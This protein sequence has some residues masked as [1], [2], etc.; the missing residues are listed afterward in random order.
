MRHRTGQRGGVATGNEDLGAGPHGFGAEFRQQGQYVGLI[1]VL[2]ADGAV[3]CWGHN[4]Y[5]ELGDGS[6]TG[7]MAF[8]HDPHE[9]FA[10]MVN[11]A[12]VVWRRLAS[13]H[14]ETALLDLIA[15][16]ARET[17]SPFAEDLLRDW[18]RARG[19]FWQVCPKEMLGRLEQPLDDGAA[20]ERA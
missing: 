20:L 18:D 3:Q 15:D 11:P 17:G 5:G 14:W 6:M 13:L 16:H 10:D 12:G 9:R 7:G 19:Q 1:G 4:Q 2:D 8:V